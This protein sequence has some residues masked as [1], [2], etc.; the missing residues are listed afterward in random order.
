M[1]RQ[2]TLLFCLAALLFGCE[3][4]APAVDVC[5]LI[6]EC[7]A[8]FSGTIPLKLSLGPCEGFR[9]CGNGVEVD[10]AASRTVMNAI[11]AALD[12]ELVARG[13]LPTQDFELIDA[14]LLVSGEGTLR[15]SEIPGAFLQRRMRC[16]LRTVEEEGLALLTLHHAEAVDRG[17][18]HTFSIEEGRVT[19]LTTRTTRSG[20]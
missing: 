15:E 6:A 9:A 16:S 7:P 8:E 12:R 1:T 20:H 11:A 2:H 10:E 3:P 17:R 18:S 5:S 4:P 14:S 19:R 13:E